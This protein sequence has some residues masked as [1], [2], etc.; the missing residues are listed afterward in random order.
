[1]SADP[2]TVEWVSDG[3]KPQCAPNPDFP[4]GVYADAACGAHGCA[5]GLPYPAPCCGVWL[6]KCSV[7]DNTV[8]ITA[9]G[10]ADDPYAAKIPCKLKGSA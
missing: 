9:A 7:C 10:R 3:R 6:I 8:A 2:I 5:I 4:R 1:M